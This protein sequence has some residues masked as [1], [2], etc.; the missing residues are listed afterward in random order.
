MLEHARHLNV[1]FMNHFRSVTQGHF[2]I[3][4]LERNHGPA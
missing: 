2:A 1:V 4:R 3:R